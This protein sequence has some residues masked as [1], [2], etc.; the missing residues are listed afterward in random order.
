RAAAR[1]ERAPLPGA[2][3]GK[4]RL[5][6]PHGRDAGGGVGLPGTISCEAGQTL[7]TEATVC[8]VGNGQCRPGTQK[9]A[10]N[11]SQVYLDP[12]KRYFIS[13]LPGDGVNPVVGGAGGPDA[14]GRPFDI[15]T[16]CGPY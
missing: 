9:T 16:A 7:L 6:L 10:L 4:P 11:P 15:A 3:G 2:A 12:A 1:F 8:D 14:N 5:Q 13:V